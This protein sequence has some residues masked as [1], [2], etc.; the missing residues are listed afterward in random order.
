ME[1][2]SDAISPTDLL[3]LSICPPM[4]GDGDLINAAAEFGHLHS[5]LRLKAEAARADLDTLEDLRP[6]GFIAHLHVSQI[7]IGHHVTEG[8]EEA[9]AGKMPEVQDPVRPPMKAVPED[10]IGPAFQD[11]FQECGIVTRIGDCLATGP[12]TT[13]AVLQPFVAHPLLVA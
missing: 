8:G 3:P 13:L 11:R 4:V 5:D 12:K 7:Q 2:G 6:E 1:E 10:N 9:I